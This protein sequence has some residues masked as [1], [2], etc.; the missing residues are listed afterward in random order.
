MWWRAGS[1]EE[2]R[3]SD[4]REALD[5]ASNDIVFGEGVSD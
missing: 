3:S 4:D 1:G 2:K 5:A